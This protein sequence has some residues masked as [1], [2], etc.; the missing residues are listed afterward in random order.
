MF[1]LR[2]KDVRAICVDH[3]PALVSTRVAV[4]RYVITAIKYGNAVAGLGKLASH[5]GT[6]K[7]GAG[8][9]E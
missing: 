2:M 6:R 7:P 1:V 3:D 4:A 9:G 8:N 5:H